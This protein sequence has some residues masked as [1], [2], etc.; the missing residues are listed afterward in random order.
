MVYSSIVRSLPDATHIIWMSKNFEK[1]GI[2]GTGI[3]CSTIKTFHSL[4]D[5][6]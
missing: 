5:D 6:L 3:K 1:C 4:G 2:S